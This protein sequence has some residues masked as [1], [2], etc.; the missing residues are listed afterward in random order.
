[1]AAEHSSEHPRLQPGILHARC[2]FPIL[3]L[4][5]V[6]TLGLIIMAALYF[7][8][9]AVFEE[10]IGTDEFHRRSHR[11]VYL[12]RETDMKF[13]IVIW[14][15]GM[16]DGSNA[17]RYV[18]ECGSGS[19]LFTPS[20]TELDNPLTAGF[21]FYGTFI[22]WDDLP[23]PRA[24]N[25]LW[26]LLHEE[27]LKNN[28]LLAFEEGISLFNIT[29]TPSRYS[30]YPLTTLFLPSIEYLEAPVRVST[31]EKG[32]NGLGIANY[33]QSDCDVPSD[34]D[35]YVEQLMLHVDIDSYG[36]CVHNRDLPEHLASP[37]GG[38]YL[39]E[40]LDLQA[41]YKFT[42][43]FEN[44]ICDDYITEKLWRPL[45]VGSVPVV[46]GSPTVKDWLPSNKSAIIVDNFDSP[47]DLADYLKFLAEND[48]E[49]NKYLQWK[50]TGVTNKRLLDSVKKRPWGNEQG[51]TFASD[52]EC[53]VCD[54]IHNSAK[55]TGH[56]EVQTK[57]SVTPRVADRSHFNCSSVE[58]AVSR[59]LW[60]LL[61]LDEVYRWIEQ[62]ECSERKIKLIHD[63]VVSNATQSE[64]AYHLRNSDF[65]R[66]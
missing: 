17:A 62:E 35:A 20:R 8:P 47:K 63:L 9:D 6:L 25:H 52:F 50:E 31:A 65:R 22:I 55:H 4:V 41:Q 24:S 39:E 37:L 40:F 51:D 13:P 7:T 53:F 19:C 45:H 34:R 32:R 60:S 29:S 23:L 61:S 59:G 58:P 38:M 5:S 64:L 12:P 57:R 54:Y 49:Y 15:S 33:V 27:S 1:M 18:R 30:D 44:A 11:I 28:W 2:A 66:C 10:T 21:L 16:Q 3:L 46:R 36:A 26:F 56:S 42:L 14:W 43:V 48:E